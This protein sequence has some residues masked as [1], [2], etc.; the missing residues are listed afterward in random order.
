MKF[1]KSAALLLA[2]I[3]MLST[4]ACS[5][6]SIH[7]EI[8]RPSIDINIPLTLPYGFADDFPGTATA[9]ELS[10]DE[11]RAIEQVER[12]F[13]IDLSSAEKYT[14]DLGTQYTGDDYVVDIDSESGYWTYINLHDANDIAFPEL[15]DEEAIQI[16][17]EFVAKNKLWPEEISD[18]K[19]SPKYPEAAADSYRPYY[20][21]VFLYPTVDGMPVS[22][23]F[24]INIDIGFSGEVR[25]VF[26]LVNPIGD[27]TNVELKSRQELAED[28]KAGN[29]SASFSEDLKNA[30]ISDFRL[31]YYADR[32][33]HGG[34]TY[35]LPVYVMTGS[36]QTVDG[37]T[38]T[39]SLTIDA[40]KD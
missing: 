33:L 29:Y 21:S 17:K 30:Q 20:K 19:V 27:S 26:C 14:G 18:A 31:C 6:G 2:A 8:A 40:Q 12:C 22:G 32:V 13:G 36:G 1:R 35:L 38:E 37:R 3:L 11:S 23:V 10:I 34:K 24:R 7:P 16:A 9:Y 25:S 5:D 4:S 15:S 39:F 28:V